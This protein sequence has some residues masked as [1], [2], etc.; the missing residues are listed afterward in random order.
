L[1]ET[2]LLEVQPELVGRDI[3]EF[4]NALRHPESEEHLAI[5][6]ERNAGIS[7]LDPAESRPTDR[8]ALG[9]DSRGNAPASTR[10]AHVAA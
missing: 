4:A 9:H 8:G 5:V 10:S 7:P 1:G 2:L 6:L 3:R